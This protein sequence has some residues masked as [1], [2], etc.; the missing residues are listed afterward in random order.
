MLKGSSLSNF[1]TNDFFLK[2]YIPYSPFSEIQKCLG[3][4]VQ[5]LKVEILEGFARLAYDFRVS[6]AD[7]K[8]VFNT[9]LFEN[10]E[11]AIKRLAEYLNYKIP[12]GLKEK[13]FGTAKEIAK[14]LIE[15]KNI[16]GW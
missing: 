6:S 9:V 8:C 7:E 14:Q 4:Q 15:K 12:A 1:L 16:F 10:R 5:D 2:K 11:H 13:M 3:L